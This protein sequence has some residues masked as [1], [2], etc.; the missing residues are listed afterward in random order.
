MSQLNVTQLGISIG[1]VKYIPKKG[2]L[3]TPLRWCPSVLSWFI[4]I[5]SD[6]I[7]P[8]NPS[9]TKLANWGTTLWVIPGLLLLLL[10]F[11]PLLAP[12]RRPPLWRAPLRLAPAAAAPLRAAAAAL[13][14]AAAAPATALTLGL[15]RETL[16]PWKSGEWCTKYYLLLLYLEGLG[17]CHWVDASENTSGDGLT[18]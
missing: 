4:K 11:L 12:P 15:P 7:P 6:Y 1:D 16:T 18:F 9:K 5:I 14:A 13:A 2:H 8:I 10:L 3:P 17:S